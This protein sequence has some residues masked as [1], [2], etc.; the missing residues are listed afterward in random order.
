MA[1]GIRGRKRIEDEPLALCLSRFRGRPGFGR[2]AL[3]PP[4][5]DE[6][7]KGPFCLGPAR[8]EPHAGGNGDTLMKAARDVTRIETALG[9]PAGSHEGLSW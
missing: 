2:L 6:V 9:A 7:P 4:V 3:Q 8:G 5:L 1:A